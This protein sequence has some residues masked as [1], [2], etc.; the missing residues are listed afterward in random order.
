MVQHAVVRVPAQTTVVIYFSFP[1]DPGRHATSVTPTL[2]YL[3]FRMTFIQWIVGRGETEPVDATARPSSNH[4]VRECTKSMGR[5]PRNH[6]A[7]TVSQKYI[8]AAG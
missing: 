4:V 5:L 3:Y 6:T 8:S 7:T 1:L 2:S